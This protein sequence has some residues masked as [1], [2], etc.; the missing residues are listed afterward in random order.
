MLGAPDMEEVLLSFQQSLWLYPQQVS[1]WG[2]PSLVLVPSP[3]LLLWTSTA[4]LQN[5]ICRRPAQEDVTEAIWLPCLPCPSAAPGPGLPRPPH[6]RWPPCCSPPGASSGRRW[7]RW[8]GQTERSGRR[9]QSRWGRPQCCS[10]CW[11]PGRSL[12]VCPGRRRRDFL[13]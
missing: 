5:S 9:R 1:P 3:P 2:L 13:T 8:R 6:S 10:R 7:R 11:F 4:N 12:L